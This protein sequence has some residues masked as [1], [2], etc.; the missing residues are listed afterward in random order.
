MTDTNYD[1]DMKLQCMKKYS[2]YNNVSHA[3]N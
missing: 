1:N 3:Y 2:F